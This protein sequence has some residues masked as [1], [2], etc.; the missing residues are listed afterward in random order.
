MAMK[1]VLTLALATILLASPATAA[2]RPAGILMQYADGNGAV[3][4]AL[5]AMPGYDMSMSECRK[6]M[7]EQVG[8]L[9]AS[10]RSDR[11]YF[12][13]TLIDAACVYLDSVED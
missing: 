6:A 11:D 2:T 12:G 5:F 4:P 9:K 13:L 3:K 8:V 10:L 7:P 1:H